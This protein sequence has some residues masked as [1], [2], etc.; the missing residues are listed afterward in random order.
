MELA[1]CLKVKAKWG[2]GNSTTEVKHFV[3]T[4][5]DTNISEDTPT[6]AYLRK[7]CKFKN[8]LPGEDWC[9]SFMRRYRLSCKLPS[10]R[11]RKVEGE[12]TSTKKTELVTSTPN[13]DKEDSESDLLS[14][15]ES[16]ID[17]SEEEDKDDE[18]EAG[19]VTFNAQKYLQLQK[20]KRVIE[21]EYY[22]DDYGKLYIGR[23]ATGIFK[24]QCEDDIPCKKAR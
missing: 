15:E 8:N 13:K 22:A 19:F 14:M 24:V 17:S 1:E 10:S 2:F 6:G 4:L 21:N 9:I 16:D 11:K 23:V 3:K 12:E 7:Y 5:V 18:E 20:K